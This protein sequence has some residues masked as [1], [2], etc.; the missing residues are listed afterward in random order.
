MVM[1][2]PVRL[3]VLALMLTA[4]GGASADV[5]S[6]EDGGTPTPCSERLAIDTHSDDTTTRHDT[7]ELAALAYHRYAEQFDFP[8][9]IPADG[10]TVRT[11]ESG[12]QALVRS[13]TVEMTAALDEGGWRISE[14]RECQ[15]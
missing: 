4:C 10:Y 11:G 15:Q 6:S 8:I 2:H 9:A 14:V 1:W 7:P 13:G 3:A 5:A 12:K